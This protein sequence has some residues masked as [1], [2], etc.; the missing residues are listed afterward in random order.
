MNLIFI[1]ESNHLLTAPVVAVLAE[2]DC[3]ME[4][5]AAKQAEVVCDVA[6]VLIQDFTLYTLL[7]YLEQFTMN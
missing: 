2:L 1:K 6:L 4:P 3:P 5:R 7:S